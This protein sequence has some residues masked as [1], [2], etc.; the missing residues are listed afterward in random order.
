MRVQQRLSHE[1]KA[2]GIQH[3]SVTWN[4]DFLE[5]LQHMNK[6]QLRVAKAKAFQMLYDSF[7]SLESATPMDLPIDDTEDFDAEVRAVIDAVHI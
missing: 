2:Q 3:I 5:S 7:V 6:G 1:L 4:E